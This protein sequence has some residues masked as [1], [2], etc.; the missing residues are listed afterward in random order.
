M[1]L[2]VRAQVSLQ[3]FGIGKASFTQQ[4][5]QPVGVGVGWGPRADFVPEQVG[6]QVGSSQELGLA[7]VAHIVVVVPG[8]H[9]VLFHLVGFELVEGREVGQTGLPEVA[10]MFVLPLGLLLELRV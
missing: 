5:H 10:L 3:R 7:N 2:I 4:T 1:L 8:R 6:L 9:T